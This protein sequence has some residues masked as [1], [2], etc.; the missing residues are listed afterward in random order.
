VIEFSAAAVAD[1]EEIFEFNN[2]RDP[3]TALDH[4]DKIRSAIRILD[5]HPEIGMR[6]YANF[7]LRELVISRG[8]SGY[9]ALYAYFPAANRV[10]ILSIKHQ[11][12]V[13]YRSH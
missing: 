5:T 13:G 10:R 11:R 7:R 3:D 2:E 4:V 9:I 6:R 1:L 12:E 8:R